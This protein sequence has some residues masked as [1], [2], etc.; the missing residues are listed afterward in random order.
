[1]PLGRGMRDKERRESRKSCCFIVGD[2]VSQTTPELFL[3]DG[4][5]WCRA[6]RRD[7]LMPLSLSISFLAL[8]ARCEAL[9]TFLPFDLTA[10]RHKCSPEG[11]S[12]HSSWPS[13]ISLVSPGPFPEPK[14]SEELNFNSWPPPSVQGPGGARLGEPGSCISCS[15]PFLVI[16]SLLLPVPGGL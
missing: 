12:Q 2:N 7:S 1:M 14:P 4:G 3:I 13:R 9:W 10:F 6:A 16:H 15:C 8:T 11:L 5:N